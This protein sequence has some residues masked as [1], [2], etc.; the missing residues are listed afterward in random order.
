VPHPDIGYRRLPAVQVTFERPLT[1]RLDGEVMGRVR[2]LSVRI[3]PEAL[4]LT[5]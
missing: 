1:V 5:V 2:D 3:E 4:S